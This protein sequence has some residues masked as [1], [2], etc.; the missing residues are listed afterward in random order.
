MA[1]KFDKYR[2]SVTD[3]KRED[4][5]AYFVSCAAIRAT[6]VIESLET[7]LDKPVVTSNSVVM[8]HILQRVGA[9][10]SISGFGRLLQGRS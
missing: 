7:A 9:T 1:Q 4:G 10:D 6:D 3:N 5:N 8:W 2:M